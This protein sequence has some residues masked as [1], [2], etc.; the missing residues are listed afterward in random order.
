MLGGGAAAALGVCVGN[1]VKDVLDDLAGGVVAGYGV[2][3]L[4]AVAVGVHKSN[5][6]DVH[7]AGLCHSTGLLLGVDN[8]KRVGRFV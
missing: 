1:L 4:R 7:L 8:K 2:R 3:N 6:G 5:D